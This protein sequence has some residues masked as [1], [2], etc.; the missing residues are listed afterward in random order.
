LTTIGLVEA[1]GAFSVI[2]AGGHVEKEPAELAAFETFA[3]ISTVPG[4]LAVAMPFWSM[5]TTVAAVVF[6][7]PLLVEDEPLDVEVVPVL[8]IVSEANCKWPAR[9]LMFVWLAPVPAN[10]RAE[11]C[12]VL[13]CETQLFGLYGVTDA[14]GGTT[15]DGAIVQHPFAS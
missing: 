10:T 11:S 12:V 3:E 7:D 1:F 6:V 15:T 8:V 2:E 5:F 4:W 14:E 13:P 9:Q